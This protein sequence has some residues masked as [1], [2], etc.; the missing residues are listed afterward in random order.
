MNIG[1][2]PARIAAAGLLV[3]RS[4]DAAP[5]PIRAPHHA[6]IRESMDDLQ[7]ATQSLQDAFAT[8]DKRAIEVSL[9][10]AE[11]AIDSAKLMLEYALKQVRR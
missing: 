9:C 7:N 3:G 11:A 4:E 1:D 6:A 10:M 5:A 2:L 8:S